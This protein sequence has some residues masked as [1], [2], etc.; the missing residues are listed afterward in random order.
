MWGA[1]RFELLNRFRTYKMRERL[2]PTYHFNKL[3]REQRT[4]RDDQ[5]R[6]LYKEWLKFDNWGT[7]PQAGGVDQWFSFWVEIYLWNG[8]RARSCFGRGVSGKR[9]RVTKRMFDLSWR[10]ERYTRHALWSLLHLPRL[11]NITNQSQAH[12]SCVSWQH[13]EFNTNEVE[14]MN[15]S[16]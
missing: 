14:G 13:S 7:N 6:C 16:T 12:L 9:R 3:H 8:E 1:L 4:V 10:G 11:R 15:T 5:L 2:H